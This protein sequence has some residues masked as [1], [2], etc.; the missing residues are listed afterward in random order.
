[1]VWNKFVSL[2]NIFFFYGFSLKK[3]REFAIVIVLLCGGPK[4][5]QSSGFACVYLKMKVPIWGL[6]LLD[7]S[8]YIH[9]LSSDRRV[10]KTYAFH[11]LPLACLLCVD[12]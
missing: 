9:F 4:E 5:N 7:D 6:Y 10:R 12:C 11:V 2:K 3:N 8:F 1:M